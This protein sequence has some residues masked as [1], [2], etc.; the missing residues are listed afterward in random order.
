MGVRMP[1]HDMRHLVATLMLDDDFGNLAAVQRLLG[2]A[3]PQ[4]T[5][6]TYGTARTAAAQKVYA[7]VV[8]KLRGKAAVKEK[9]RARR[10]SKKPETQL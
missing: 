10:K 3:T 9:A 5:L 8:E 7:A 2:H 1:P 4:T 6:K